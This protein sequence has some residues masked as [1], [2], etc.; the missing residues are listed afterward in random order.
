[1]SIKEYFG[2]WANIINLEEADSIMRKLASSKV[3]VCPE[4]KDIFKAFRMCSYKKLS[5]VIIG[6]DPYPTLI[7]NK[8]VATGIAFANDK[9]TQEDKLS[10]SLKVLTDSVID[11]TVPH[12]IIKFD[13]SLE[14]WEKQGILLLN[15]SLS[16]KAGEPG[17]HAL[18]WRVFIKDFLKKLSSCTSGMIYLLLGSEAQSFQ[19]YISPAT[20]NILCEKHPSWYY[21]NKQGMPSDFWREVEKLFKYIN[22]YDLKL[23]NEYNY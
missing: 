19:K 18:L 17:S 15:T 23:Y 22:G 5:M 12:G 9:N 10:P 13:Y 8:P 7:D 11:Y 1:M 3:K 21:R 14:E 20:S 16:C 2:D 6:Q 4:L